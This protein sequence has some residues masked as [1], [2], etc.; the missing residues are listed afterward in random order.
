MIRTNKI[1]ALVKRLTAIAR[2]AGSRSDSHPYRSPSH[3]ISLFHDAKLEC[4]DWL[5]YAMVDHA[6]P[7]TRNLI[8]RLPN[9]SKLVSRSPDV[10][11][12]VGTKSQISD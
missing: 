10:P 11:S 3:L 8:A 6:A 1:E 4:G 5:P 7:Y 12:I 2:A 9:D